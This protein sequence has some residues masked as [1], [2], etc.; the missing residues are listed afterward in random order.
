M[1]EHDLPA[2]YQGESI[3]ALDV[4][5]LN[6]HVSLFDVVEGVFRHVASAEAPSTYMPPYFD[7]NEGVRHALERLKEITGRDL[8]DP[9]TSRLVSPTTA[10]GVGADIIVATS[11]AGVPVRTVLV[12]LLPNVSVQMLRRLAETSY[13]DV[14][15]HMHL[16][17]GRRDEK[18]IDLLVNSQPDLIIIGGGTEGGAREAVLKLSENVGLAGFLMPAHHRARVLFVGNSAVKDQLAERVDLPLTYAPNVQPA[19][20][21]SF[22]GRAQAELNHLVE[23]LRLDQ[24]GGLREIALA[25]NGHAWPTVHAE[26]HLMRHFARSLQSQKGLLSVNV[27]AGQTSLV[28]TLG[29]E[30]IVTVNT[31]SSVGLNA[32]GILT[33][34]SLEQFKRWV[35][36]ADLTDAAIRDFVHNKAAYPFSIPEDQ[37]DTWMEYAL[38]RLALQVTLRRARTHWPKPGA[39]PDLL[40]P[41]SLIVGGGAVLTHA[42]SRGLA[43]LT[44]LDALQPVGITSLA[45]DPH[46]LLPA[47][48]AVAFLNPLA[49]VQVLESGCLF[50][51]GTVVSVVGPVKLGQVVCEATLTYDDGRETKLEVTSGSFEVMPLAS[52][53]GGK[54]ALKPRPGYDFGA[55]AGRSRKPFDV[56]GG[57]L[58]VIIDARGRPISLPTKPDRRAELLQ[59]WIWKMAAL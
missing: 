16:I 11:S 33:E 20:G 2:E 25:A 12:G 17:D 51:L 59:K 48:G 6:T 1:S 34:A 55:G 38:A 27:G 47:L 10:E 39:R 52:G 49:T 24:V 56:S 28:A 7:V 58:G 21:Q 32:P 54:L 36:K 29:D 41:M 50:D 42:P 44:L 19:L 40:P 22:V 8:L 35:P 30:T 43:A 4:G 31:T 53:Q 18:Q 3:L 37:E 9:E 15:D 5:T 45:L 13:L 14:R 26:A 23:T 57:A 46:H